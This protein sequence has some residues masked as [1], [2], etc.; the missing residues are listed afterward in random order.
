MITVLKTLPPKTFWICA[1]MSRA[2]AVRRPLVAVLVLTGQASH[3]LLRIGALHVNQELVAALVARKVV[4]VPI[5]KVRKDL[6]LHLALG[7]L[8]VA[9]RIALIAFAVIEA[10]G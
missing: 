4:P 1:R 10:N 8:P 5:E 2:S 3:Q 6:R 7:N 9:I